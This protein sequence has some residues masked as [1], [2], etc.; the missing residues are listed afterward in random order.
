MLETNVLQSII[1]TKETKIYPYIRKIDLMSSN[2]FILSAEE[3]IVLIDTGALDDQADHLIERIALMIEEKPR[4]VV[5]YLT[6]CH[7][8]HCLQL[9]RFR[10][11]E[12][13][14]NILVAAQEKGAEAIEMQD[15]KLT[16]S[17]L[18]GKKLAGVSIDIRLLSDKDI[19]K[20][21]KQHV[22][23]NGVEFTYFTKS[24][25][26]PHGSILNSQIVNLGK[27]DQL[28]IYHTPGHSPD[29]VCIRVGSLLFVGDLFFAPNP[30][31]A[32][33][34]GWSQSDLLAA[35]QKVIFILEQNEK[36]LLCCSGHGR[37]I[38][39]NTAWSTLRDMYQDVLSLSDLEDV[40]PKW[41]K[42]T[43]AYAEE[44]MREL[45]RLFTIIIGRLAYISHVL[46]E[47]EEVNEANYWHSL[48]DAKQIDDLFSEFNWFVIELRDGKKLDWGLVHKAGQ[49]IGKLDTIFE[50]R[51]LGSILNQSLLKRVNRL[52]NDYAITYRGFRPTYYVT[53]VDINEVIKEILE[54]SRYKPYEDE[55]ILEADN[56]EDYIW[57]LR[58]R[59]AHVN[60]FDK[61]NLEF[62]EN[63][64]LPLVRMDRERFNEALIDILERLISA[65]AKS[66]RITTFC[67]EGLIALQ[68]SITK[69]V[70]AIL[71]GDMTMRFF[72]RTLA[73]CG[74]FIET[75]VSPEGLVVEIEFLPCTK[76]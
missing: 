20:G 28:E 39:A 69:S 50:N 7:L 60:I 35:I 65:G 52:L 44:L 24:I 74:G 21:G 49:T 17:D 40:T 25:K 19:L 70:H 31:V 48:I 68:I 16:L 15:A 38:D 26:I 13:L 71:L 53:D 3:Q 62:E 32:G 6:H 66:I 57:A 42:N 55:A 59:I 14:G 51:K 9:S 18:L 8:D 61:I 5:I 1:G 34:Y 75:Y 58:K 2:S 63:Q 47:L 23:P 33:A 76:F 30:G 22:H 11:F 12:D 73:L 56:Y 36:I 4:P 72:E 10:E 46:N 64:T 37:A 54:F 41:A 67:N 27:D 45:E 43:A 29:S